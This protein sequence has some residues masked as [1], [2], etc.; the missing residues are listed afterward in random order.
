M[1]EQVGRCRFETT[2]SDSEMNG[3]SGIFEVSAQ[4]TSNHGPVHVAKT[5][6]FSYSDGTPY[7]LLGTTLYN[8]LNRDETLQRQTLETLSQSPFTKV[9]FGL[10]PKWYIFNREE[11]AIYPYVQT[12]PHTFVL[13]RF[14]PAGADQ[15]AGHPCAPAPPRRFAEARHRQPW[16]ERQ[17]E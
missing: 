6:H 2:S 9:R 5:Y 1:P 3:Q 13:D 8:W 4:A 14:D 16:N 17:N 15:H 7:F 10:F 11:P 12:G